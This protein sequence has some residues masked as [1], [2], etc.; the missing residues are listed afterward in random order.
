MRFKLVVKFVSLLKKI[1]L[2]DERAAQLARDI[3]RK[4]EEEMAFPGQIKVNVIREK[5]SIEYAK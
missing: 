1:I 3:A 4:I 2:D 5:R